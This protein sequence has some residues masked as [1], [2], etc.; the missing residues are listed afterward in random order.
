MSLKTISG[1]LTIPTTEASSGGAYSDLTLQLVFISGFT[2]S[3]SQTASVST[4]NTYSF[5]YTDNGQIVKVRLR[6]TSNNV[7]L[8]ESK[9]RGVLPRSFLNPPADFWYTQTKN[10]N[11]LFDAALSIIA[12]AGGNFLSLA[13]EISVGIT[14]AASSGSTVPFQANHVFPVGAD[15]SM[16]SFPYYKTS[17]VAACAY[18]LGFYLEKNPLALNKVEVAATLNNLLIWLCARRDLPNYDGLLLAGH[19]V[20]NDEADYVLS[21]DNILAYFAFKQAGVILNPTY[22]N[23]A[24]SLSTAIKF[25]LLTTDSNGIEVVFAGINTSGNNLAYNLEADVFGALFWVEENDTAKAQ[26][27]MTKIESQY[28]GVDSLNSVQA[29]KARFTDTKIWLEGS[30]AV[31]LAYYKLG[32]TA[33][34][35]KITKELN[36]QLNDDGSFRFGMLKDGQL[37]VLYHK[38]VGSTAWSYFT[39]ILPG[40]AFSINTGATITTGIVPVYINTL[41]L[42]TFTRSNCPSGQTA[43]SITYAVLPGSHHSTVDQATADAL[44][45]A[46]LT[47]N[48]QAFADAH[49]TCTPAYTFFN[50][51]RT[52][53]FIKQGCLPSQV[54]SVHSYS[55]TGHSFG[56]I[57]SQQHAEALADAKL[58]LDGQNNANI[59]SGTCSTSQH[60]VNITALTSVITNGFDDEVYVQFYASEPLITPVDITYEYNAGGGWTSGGIITMFAGAATTFSS[61]VDSVPF[62]S[63]ASVLIRITDVTPSSIGSQLY[64]WNGNVNIFYNQQQSA[65]FIKNDCGLAGV[66]AN[67]VLEY[68]VPASGYTSIISQHYAD[69]LA[70]QDIELNGQDWVNSHAVCAGVTFYPNTLQSGSFIKSGCTFGYSGET[71]TYSVPAGTFTSTISTAD[72]NSIAQAYISA[73]GQSYAQTFGGCFLS[74]SSIGV[75]LSIRVDPFGLWDDVYI[76]ATATSPSQD[77]LTIHTTY[78]LYG[79][80]GS[81]PVIQLLTTETVGSEYYVGQFS[82]GDGN[83]VIAHITSITP[84]SSGGINYIIQ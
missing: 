81:G 28:I 44:A 76:K 38:S 29:Y 55:V 43:S 25:R 5:T 8:S 80:T 22:L 69:A 21:P 17:T 56:S 36:K 39:N 23:V 20:S 6:R 58:L 7:V 62:G 32:N 64:D 77:D 26:N 27:L 48:G 37:N 24:I 83:N 11:W 79:S 78:E 54:G 66:D 16:V 63:G 46:D 84:S 73:H 51:T 74:G 12:A 3:V 72:A 33:K 18:A 75:S 14:L 45:D 57:I 70:V 10:D 82:P 41:K 13:K 9:S 40:Q 1:T 15:P 52:A 4:S 60:V 71:V 30:Y 35:G 47:A 59:I 42:G 2:E 50:T 68:V 67:S 34:Y 19:G 65:Y 49:G 61:F 31:A 53:K